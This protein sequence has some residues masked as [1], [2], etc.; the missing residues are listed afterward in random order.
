MI[1]ECPACHTRYRT[2][3]SGVIDDNTFFECSQ[4]ECR[5]VFSYSPPLFGG[6]GNDV[7]SRSAPPLAPLAEHSQAL[8]G[9]EPIDPIPS[10]PAYTMKPPRKAPLDELEDFSP[11]EVPFYADTEGEN[12]RIVFSRPAS[13]SPR[14]VTL[15]LGPFL[16]LLGFIVLGHAALGLYCLSH[17]A[18]TEAALARLPLLGSLFTA[19]RFS[20]QHI[21]LSELAGHYWVTKDNLRVFAVFGKA[22]NTAPLPSRSI[23][24]EG[25]I[26]DASGKVAGQRVIFCGTETAPARLASLTVREIGILQNLVPPKQFNVPAG[27]AV[28]FLI[29]FTSP[30]ASI[31]EFS[32]RVVAAQFGG[33]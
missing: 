4:E 29:V 1:V 26:Y 16:L 32:S 18:D 3:S 22:T 6:G 25:A 17:P 30:P 21:A 8:L 23:Q 12:R 10:A 7:A 20:A 15:S 28:D 2:D 19:E 13:E 9:E 24:I 5:H 27:Q 11:Q 33:S 14:E 31:A